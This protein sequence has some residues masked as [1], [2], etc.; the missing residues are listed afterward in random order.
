MAGAVAFVPALLVLLAVAGEGTPRVPFGFYDIK[1]ADLSSTD[2][3]LSGVSLYQ[4]PN[5]TMALQARAVRQRVRSLLLVKDAFFSGKGIRPDFQSAWGR[6]EKEA[7]PLFT[8]GTLLGFNLG[9]ELVWNCVEPSAIRTAVATIRQSFPAGEAIIWYNEAAMDLSNAPKDSCG[10]RHPDFTIPPQ[11]DWFSVDIY[12]MDGVV[13]GWVSSH[14]KTYYEKHIFPNITGPNQKAVLVP[15]SFGS[16]VNHNCNKSCYDIMI[17]HDAVDFAEWAVTDPRIAAVMPWNW[18]G[19]KTC[20]GSRW[21][22]PH[23]CCM[24]EIGTVDMTLSRHAWAHLF[25]PPL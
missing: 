24:D 12:H 17:S 3:D 23:T 13:D 6:I 2:P 25:P 22:P 7:R 4:A 18:G 19:C 10:K 14:V 11:L 16:H 1:I 8:N 9:D 15:G 20:N 5:V 21:T